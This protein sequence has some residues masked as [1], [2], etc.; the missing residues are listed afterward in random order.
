M[1]QAM[2][3][4]RGAFKQ[5]TKPRT[6]GHCRICYEPSDIQ[7]FLSL[8]PAR[9]SENDF[10]PIL[11]DGCRCFGR[12]KEIAYYIPWL[13]EVCPE[14]WLDDTDNFLSMLLRALEDTEAPMDREQR[15]AIFRFVL[16]H[17]EDAMSDSEG[18]ASLYIDEALVFLGAFGES[19]AQMFKDLG[20]SDDLRIR[21]NYC[22]FIARQVLG[23]T[24]R[25]EMSDENQKAFDVLLEPSSALAILMANVNTV[26]QIAPDEQYNVEYAFDY[27]TSLE[28]SAVN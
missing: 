16:A 17:T 9:M 2:V 22:L 7:K 15:H 4:L 11:W 19:I 27:L 23:L 25:P 13:L 26:S 20:S 24:T 8:D 3:E 10:L 14:P 28:N 12:W 21:A 18:D 5:R 1:D 6:I